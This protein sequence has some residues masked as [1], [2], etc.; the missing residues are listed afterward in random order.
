MAVQAKPRC[1]FEI[2][3]KIIKEHS[4][5]KSTR[6]DHLGSHKVNHDPHLYFLAGVVRIPAP[7]AS[8]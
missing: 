6:S 2:D 8:M 1:I 5:Y 4:P 3:G 7:E